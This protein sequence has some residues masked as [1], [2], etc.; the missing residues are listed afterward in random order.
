M[1]QPQRG[2]RRHRAQLL[3][4]YLTVPYLRIPL[5]A[6]FLADRARVKAQVSPQL[7][8]LVDG[9]FFEAGPWRQAGPLAL[10]DTIPVT[11]RAVLATPA[12]L[13]LHEFRCSPEPLIEAL[14]EL[15]ELALEIDT[16]RHV[17]ASSPIVLY[18][19][20]LLARVDGYVRLPVSYTHLT[21]PTK[22]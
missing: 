20:R 1:E 7:Q 21:L 19:I 13:L 12:G 5:I 17:R 10:P 3:Q 11:E 22:A 14:T 8:A 2:A 6:R 18:V 4:Q 16:G 9:V 15:L